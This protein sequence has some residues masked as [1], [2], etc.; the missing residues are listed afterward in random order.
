VSEADAR[1]PQQAPA[2]ACA[3]HP[4]DSNYCDPNLIRTTY[5]VVNAGTYNAT[6][7]YLLLALLYRFRP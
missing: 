7:H 2:S 1:V 4:G 3:M 6:S 5:P